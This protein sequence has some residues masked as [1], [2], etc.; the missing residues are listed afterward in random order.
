[1]LFVIVEIFVDIPIGITPNY[2]KNSFCYKKI[3]LNEVN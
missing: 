2:M 1:M 3:D